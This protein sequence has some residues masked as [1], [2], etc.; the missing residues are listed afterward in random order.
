MLSK[1][2]QNETEPDWLEI[3]ALSR[4]LRQQIV[5]LATSLKERL[6]PAEKE[7]LLEMFQ[8]QLNLQALL[9]NRE[10]PADLLSTQTT[11]ETNTAGDQGAH[12]QALQYARDLAKVVRQKKVQQRRLDM[13]LEQLVRA[14]KSAVV[15][16]VAASVAH[17]L[18][19]ILAPL[20]TYA[21]S[22][23]DSSV[24]QPPETVEFSKQLDKITHRASSLLTQL[25]NA[26]A[27]ESS[28]VS[29]INL[30]Q[31]IQNSLA[32][33]SPRIKSQNIIVEQQFYRNPP[34]IMGNT[35]QFEQVFT[36]IALNAIDAMPNGG[37]FSVVIAP[38]PDPAQQ[39]DQV[40][41]QI[42]DSGVGIPPEQIELIFE[43]FYTT[44]TQESNAGLGLFVSQLI[45][46]RYGGNIAVE[47]ELGRGT[48][49][50][51]NL[52]AINP[53]Q[54]QN[55]LLNRGVNKPA[56]RLVR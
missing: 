12:A 40:T 7:K 19:N 22:Y 20:L 18:S 1:T 26:S 41:V 14:E 33:L 53:R 27:D 36:N 17:E 11:L 5:S 48:T 24:I 8:T 6:T 10:E 42:K 9:A 37:E 32:L 51:L 49:F 38:K 50:T 25:I 34:L 31:T 13:T 46:D 44:K 39:P 23:H 35:T 16:Q 43:P 29:L 2:K 15:G 56:D 30:I 21:Q 47:S 4:Q 28:T 3:T 45:V 55:N 54:W 52:P